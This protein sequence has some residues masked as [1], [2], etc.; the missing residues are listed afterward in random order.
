MSDLT[1]KI[2]TRMRPGEAQRLRHAA[3]Y[4]GC[5]V[6]TLVRYLAAAFYERVALE[7]PNLAGDEIDAFKLGTPEADE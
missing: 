4:I 2:T 1:E 6:N 5:S 7:G 3:R